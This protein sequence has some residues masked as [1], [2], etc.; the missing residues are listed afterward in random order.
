[1]YRPQPIRK[2]VFGTI[3]MLLISLF[4]AQSW[5]DIRGSYLVDQS[6]LIETQGIVQQA[7]VVKRSRRKDVVWR[8]QLRYRYEVDGRSYESGEITFADTYFRTSERA[9]AFVAA[10]PVGSAVAVFYERGNPGFAVLNPAI[11]KTISMELVFLAI[12]CA[13]L[14]SGAYDLMRLRRAG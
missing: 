12:G 5:T 14:L 8:P 9:A 4:I 2:L 11:R 10:R 1:M 13:L 6:D 7:E 3:W